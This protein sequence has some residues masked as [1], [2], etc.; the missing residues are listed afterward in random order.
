MRC[1]NRTKNSNFKLDELVK[2]VVTDSSEINGTNIGNWIE[3]FER[4]IK[5]YLK[6]LKRLYKGVDPVSKVQFDNVDIDEVL[7]DSKKY[8]YKKEYKFEE[9][10]IDDRW[11][12]QNWSVDDFVDLI[13]IKTPQEMEDEQYNSQWRDI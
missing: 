8:L 6:T 2:Y 9:K 12:L 3:A 5:P 11:D 1:I 4:N 7:G 10:I 13:G